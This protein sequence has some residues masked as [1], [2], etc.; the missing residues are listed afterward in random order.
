[1]KRNLFVILLFTLIMIGLLALGC[2]GDGGDGDDAGDEGP[3][4]PSTEKACFNYDHFCAD[5]EDAGDCVAIIGG[6]SLEDCKKMC[7][8]YGNDC[9]A[10]N[11]CIDGKGDLYDKYCVVENKP[12][13]DSDYPDYI[14]SNSCLGAKCSYEYQA[15]NMNPDCVKTF[16]CWK[17]CEE[18]NGTNCMRGC[19]D[20]YSVG[21]DIDDLRVCS[22]RKKCE[23]FSFIGE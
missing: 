9:D 18:N 16:Y 10:M 13:D 2:D 3:A 17:D 8:A 4:V 19:M 12:S 20:T 21:R 7:M 23:L 5:N 15:C 11:E 6:D 14:S 22:R 1:M